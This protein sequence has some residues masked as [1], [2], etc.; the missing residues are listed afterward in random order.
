MNDKHKVSE[1]ETLV[2]LTA[3]V[4]AMTTILVDYGIKYE[5]AEKLVCRALDTGFETYVDAIRGEKGMV[6]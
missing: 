3:F 4:D 2:G 5:D 1:F 6:Q